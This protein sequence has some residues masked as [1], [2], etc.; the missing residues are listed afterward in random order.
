MMN[1]S[2]KALSWRGFS[3]CRVQ[4]VEKYPFLPYLV[5]NQILPVVGQAGERQHVLKVSYNGKIRVQGNTEVQTGTK[6]LSK[7]FE[8]WG[9]F[10]EI[11]GFFQDFRFFFQDFMDF[12]R[13]LK[14]FFWDY[15]IFL[16][17]SSKCQ[18]FFMTCLPFRVRPKWESG[19]STPTYEDR[20]GDTP[21]PAQISCILIIVIKEKVDLVP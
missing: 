9:F 19:H 3:K 16:D 14:N 13:D 17:C 2:G 5:R 10:F 8:V 21:K 15:F 7:I 11:F 6:I 20:W 4:I 18:R 1:L 12:F